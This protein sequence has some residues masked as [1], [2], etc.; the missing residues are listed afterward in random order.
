[1]RAV[2]A[3]AIVSVRAWG[4]L[5]GD[6]KLPGTL[7]V[8]VAG[9]SAGGV[10]RVGAEWRACWYTAAYRDQFTYHPTAELAV[11]AVLASGWARRLGT[12]KASRVIWS[13][14]ARRV[15]ARKT[16]ARAL[17]ETIPI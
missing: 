17:E 12:R 14:A 5:P 10:E 11:A 8:L 7:R 15:A 4:E 16:T 13:S 1:M 9:Q 2:V 3:P 6:R